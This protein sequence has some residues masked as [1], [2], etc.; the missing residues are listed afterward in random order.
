MARSLSLFISLYVYTCVSLSAT[1]HVRRLYDN[2]W[3]LVL[4][5]RSCG[6]QGAN[7]VVRLGSKNPYPMNHPSCPGSEFS[8]H[9]NQVHSMQGYRA[10]SSSFSSSHTWW[11]AGPGSFQAT[12]AV[13]GISLDTLGGLEGNGDSEEEVLAEEMVFLGFGMRSNVGLN[14]GGLMLGSGG[15]LD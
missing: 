10:S 5:F 13:L 9:L 6:S 3:E 8:Q 7:S 2:T 4:C 15:P 14:G 11:P 12:D 1:V